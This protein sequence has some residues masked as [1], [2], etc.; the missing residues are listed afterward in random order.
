MNNG[1]NS[2]EAIMKLLRGE[3][4]DYVPNFSGM[5]SITLYGIKQLSYRFNEALF[6]FRERGGAL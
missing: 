5:G 6:R 2:K 1:R 3:K 4:I